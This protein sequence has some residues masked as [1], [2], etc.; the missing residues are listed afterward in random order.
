MQD[1]LKAGV[2]EGVGTFFL[3][4]IGAGS[5][6]LDA[7]TSGRVGLLGIALAH[8]LALSV[9]VSCTLGLSG[10]H[11][12]PAV[13]FGFMV[14]GRMERR[15]GLYYMAAQLAGAVVAGV[16][17]RIMF[18]EHVWR[19]RAL[20]TPDLD[21][22]VATGTGIFIEA[23]MTFLLVFSFWA[24]AVDPRGPKIAG[25][26]IGMTLASCTLMGGAL[27]GASLN[28]A[29]A[30]GPALA[31]FHWS[32]HLIYWIGPLLGGAAASLVYDGFLLEKRRGGSPPLD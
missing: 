8:G 16:F 23:V 27:T 12:N 1:S 7:M 26:G 19:S 9:A 30:F 3:V 11:L 28:P 32:N 6:C 21:P 4:F 13:T 22:G 17:L 29:R 14:T 10:G 20:G 31:S 24:T 15:S 5:I 2:A 25:F 18:D